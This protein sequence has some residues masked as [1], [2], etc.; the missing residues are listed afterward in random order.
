LAGSVPLL[1][2]APA[3]AGPGDIATIAGGVGSGLATQ[4]RQVP[5]YLLIAGASVYVSDT[6]Q[7]VVRKIDTTTG[8][9]TIVAGGGSVNN[10]DGLPAT[11]VR[12][13]HPTGLAFDSKGDLFISDTYGSQV[14]EVKPN[15]IIYRV[16]G[17]GLGG[18]SGDG[19]PATTA[20]LSAPMGLAVDAHDNLFIADAGSN[21]IRTVD[22]TTG[23]IQTFS[24]GTLYLPSDVVFDPAGDLLILDSANARVIKVLP[25]GGGGPTIAGGG[26]TFCSNCP[27]LSTNLFDATGIGIDA[28][29]NLLI[30]NT[31]YNVIQKVDKLDGTGT[32]TTVAGG[33]PPGTFGGDGGPATAASLYHPFA[34]RANPAGGF[35]IADKENQR[36]RKV[37]AAGI[38]NTIAG[39]GDCGYAGDGGP[40]LQAQ[41]CAPQGMA[42]D[43]MGSVF[44]ADA[45]GN[46][47]RK[48]DAGGTISTVAG[49]GTAGYSGDGGPATQAKLNIPVALA[50]DAAGDLFIADDANNVVREITTD[51]VIHTIAGTGTAGFGGDGMAATLALLTS[52]AGVAIDASGNLFIADN[53]NHRV[54][55]VDHSTNIIT[56]FA[57]TGVRGAGGDGGKATDAQLDFPAGL[58]FDRSGNLLIADS[59]SN[60]IRK[61][62]PSGIISRF[63]GWIFANYFGDGGPAVDA[64]LASPVA[65]AVGPHNE[66]YIL[67]ML[68]YRVR[69]VTTDG[70][71]RTVVGTYQGFEGD[72]GPA[73]SA[74]INEAHGLA[75]DSAGDIVIGD[76]LSRRVR[77]VEAYG[78]PG[79]PAGV[80]ASPVSGGATVRWTAPPSGGM[81]I[82]S[83]TVTPYEGTVAGTP[84]TVAS[85][86]ATVT[87]LARG[88]TYVFVV[89]ATNALGS[90]PPS[91]PSNPITVYMAPSTPGPVQAIAGVQAAGV[92]WTTPVDDGGRPIVSYLVTPYA[93]SIA[94]ASSTVTGSP[95]PTSTVITGLTNGTFYTFSVAAINEVGTG[96]SAASNAVRPMGGGTYHPAP[97]ARILDT[98]YGPGTRGALSNGENRTILVA[99]QGPVPSTGVSAVVLNVTVTNTSAAG[100][101]TA[102]PTG[103]PRP[104]ASNLNWSAQQTVPN[105]VEVALGRGGQV[106]IYIY[107]SSAD[108]IF[109]VQGWVGIPA[110]SGADGLFNGLAPARILDTRDGTGGTN[111]SLGPGAALNLQVAGSVTYNAAPSGVPTTGVSA[112]VLNVTVTNPTQASYLTVYPAGSPRPVTSNLNFT[113]GQTVPNRVIVKLGTGGAITIFNA[114]GSVNVI[115]DVN[116]WFTDAST[117]IGGTDFTGISPTR[118]IDTRTANW[119]LGPLQGGTEYLIQLLDSHGAPLTGVSAIV[120]NATAT[121]TTAP[122]YLTIW[123]NTITLPVASDLN[124]L[125]GQTVPN[126]I[127]LQL[128]AGATF[129]IYNAAGNTDVAMDLVGF[130]STQDA[131]VPNTPL[132]AYAVAQGF[133][134][135]RAR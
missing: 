27:A 98:R 51:G 85:S 123:P 13:S 31:Y 40:A 102:Y 70:I 79:A 92:G 26:S 7:A 130:Y 69:M 25:T 49:T 103:V 12:F 14:W 125:A 87:G 73:T 78:V 34:V 21:R 100:Y 50:F 99:G 43:A 47:I 4:L 124:F 8:R 117:Q 133:R 6:A 75:I 114:A 16:A 11:Q 66:V 45:Q 110:N 116:G 95:P 33:G 106:D 119:G 10:A 90:G 62:D 91:P 84:T 60:E 9:E 115:A 15:G 38:I 30:A 108:V 74:R 126:L 96:P 77:R 88:H 82:T 72:G 132:H 5:E 59:G 118:I 122:G 128:G 97:P 23:I 63:A 134:V 105:L 107:G 53:G 22:M 94:L 54:R 17:V 41:L 61:V 46:R 76:T 42:F 81:P 120:V 89:A 127:V 52:P 121:N 19:I 86:P 71:I 18:Y 2:P 56:T 20:Q 80:V 37:D 32:V 28:A 55:R 135:A 64:A 129:R 83:Y 48:V 111:H 101:L 39:S 58:A 65:V 131:A 44:I 68:H 1:A 36:V 3:A 93:G 109:D 113:A 24:Y 112:V 57:G 35:F 104:T 67:D 29:G